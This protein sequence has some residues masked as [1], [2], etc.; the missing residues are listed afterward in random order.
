M[1]MEMIYST[2]SNF[3]FPFSFTSSGTPNLIVAALDVGLGPVLAVLDF[4][5]QLTIVHPVQYL[6]D[7]VDESDVAMSAAL[8]KLGKYHYMFVEYDDEDATRA[9]RRKKRKGGQDRAA[10]LL[11]LEAS[12]EKR[13][14]P[15]SDSLD[16]NFDDFNR[17]IIGVL[18]L[19]MGSAMLPL[20]D[21][22]LEAGATLEQQDTETSFPMVSSIVDHFYR[23]C[24]VEKQ[25]ELPTARAIAA[26]RR[27]L[28][29]LAEKSSDK[30]G[31]RWQRT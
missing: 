25:L 10:R 12:L 30:L 9:G 29:W 2:T 19:N 1:T 31:L 3:T 22:L 18:F 4:E 20:A 24:W 21:K 16:Y 15:F 28:L 13:W 14:K 5:W 11:A 26:L 17:S 23:R 27:A 6:R 7:Y 8:T